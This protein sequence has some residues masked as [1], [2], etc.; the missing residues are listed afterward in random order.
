MLHTFRVGGVLVS[1]DWGL[2]HTLLCSH[3]S[4]LSLELEEL[5]S[6]G[7]KAEKGEQ[8]ETP[9]SNWRREEQMSQ[10]GKENKA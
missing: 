1:S 3:N 2:N 7:Y 5:T 6:P 9:H 4:V 10:F 8:T